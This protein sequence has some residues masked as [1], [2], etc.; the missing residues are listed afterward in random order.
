MAS[1]EL[2]RCTTR[3]SL[4]AI[5]PR[6]LHIERLG[7]SRLAG[8]V[9]GDLLHPRLGLAQQLLAAALERLAA[10]VDRDRFLERHL[11]FLEPLD[12]RFELLD[13]LLE[14]EPADVCVVGFAHDLSSARA[15]QRPAAPSYHPRIS[16]ITCAATDWA[17]PCRS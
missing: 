1:S 14:G 12:D 4:L 5:R 10:L 9:E 2:R 15:T 17:R 7:A 11:A 3:Y 6:S 16:V 13:R 8:G